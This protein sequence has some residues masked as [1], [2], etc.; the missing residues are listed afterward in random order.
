MKEKRNYVFLALFASLTIGLAPLYPEPHIVGKIRWVM[1]GA[2]GMSL[3]DWLDLCM[4][5]AP[6]VI[7]IVL[8]IRKMIKPS[9]QS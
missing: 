7:L 5:G 3:M 4:H 8:L 1:G 9:I 6:W 2:N